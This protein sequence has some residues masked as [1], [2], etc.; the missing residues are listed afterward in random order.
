MPDKYQ[1]FSDGLSGFTCQPRLSAD[2]L[3]E[4]IQNIKEGTSN[5]Y[6]PS[7][8]WMYYIYVLHQEKIPYWGARPDVYKYVR[9]FSGQHVTYTHHTQ[10]LLYALTTWDEDNVWLFTDKLF[11]EN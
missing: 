7:Q 6:V 9:A 5:G 1:V 4:A 8:F 10:G 11:G 3:E 2:T